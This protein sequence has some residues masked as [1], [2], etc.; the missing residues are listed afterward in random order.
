[1]YKNKYDHVGI[2]FKN[3]DGMDKKSCYHIYFA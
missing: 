3:G 2:I 1:M